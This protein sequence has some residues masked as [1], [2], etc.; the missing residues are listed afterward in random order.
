MRRYVGRQF[1]KGLTAGLAECGS[2]ITPVWQVR[3][4]QN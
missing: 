4:G 3:D 1:A 2:I